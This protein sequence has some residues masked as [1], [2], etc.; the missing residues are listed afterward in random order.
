MLRRP[1]PDG[2]CAAV[3]AAAALTV[4]ADCADITA[5]LDDVGPSGRVSC[6]AMNVAS[7]EIARSVEK[8]EDEP[9]PAAAP[10]P[11]MCAAWPNVDDGAELTL[12]SRVASALPPELDDT[13]LAA[14][15]GP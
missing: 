2:G 9:L 14:A 11:D 5:A 13:A 4:D 10:L 12:A 15:R 7:A 8:E 3:V 6:A 1:E